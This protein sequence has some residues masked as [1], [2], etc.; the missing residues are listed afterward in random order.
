LAKDFFKGIGQAE[1]TRLNQPAL[2]CR[3]TR[4]KAARSMLNIPAGSPIIPGRMQNF[5]SSGAFPWNRKKIKSAQDLT[6]Q[7]S[8][9]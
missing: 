5:Q 2:S 7:V 6:G 9:N 8:G 4:K 1:R 3:T